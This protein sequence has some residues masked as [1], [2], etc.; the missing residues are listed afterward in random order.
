MPAKLRL[1]RHG[2]KGK[3]YFHI[4]VADSRAKRD[5]KFIEKIGIY[6]PISNPATIELNIDRAIYWLNNGAQ[7]TDTT[8][9]ILSYKGAIYKNHLN[10]GVAKGALTQAQADAKFEK[11][12]Q[13]KEAKVQAKK[14]KLTKQSAEDRK[15][16]LAAE[17]EQ[18]QAKARLILE[19]QSEISHAV[20]EEVAHE[21]APVV[22][23]E[24]PVVEASNEE[25]QPSAE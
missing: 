20:K 14:D 3:A 8:R 21:E 1:Q 16:Q 10:K 7:P 22:E 25:E 11:W 24:A 23:A 2:K 5:G 18:S 6:N 19:K 4:V 9:A 15:K 17:V 13:E 12:L